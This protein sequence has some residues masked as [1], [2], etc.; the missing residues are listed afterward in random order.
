MNTPTGMGSLVVATA[1][2]APAAAESSSHVIAS[3]PAASRARS[4]ECFD[5]KWLGSVTRALRS[6]E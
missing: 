3:N 2:G 4:I 5:Q 1:S 6:A